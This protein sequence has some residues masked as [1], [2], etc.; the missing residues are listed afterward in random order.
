MNEEY[1]W[2]QLSNCLWQYLEKKHIES[3]SYGKISDEEWNVFVNMFQDSFANEVSLLATEYWNERY[4]NGMS[5][6]EGE[7][8]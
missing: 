4:I 6:I 8:E 1:V 7:E 2:E 3:M 5:K